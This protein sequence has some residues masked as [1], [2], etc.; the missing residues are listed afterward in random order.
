MVLKLGAQFGKDFEEYKNIE[1]DSS[2][3]EEGLI[4]Y[5]LN[6]EIPV[7]KGDINKKFRSYL[8]NSILENENNKCV[9]LI[10]VSPR[11]TNEQPLA[12]DMLTKSI[13]SNFIFTTPLSDN[14]LSDKYKRDSESKNVVA[15]MNIMFEQSLCSWNKDATPNDLSQLKLRRVYASKSIMAWTELFKD[16]ICAKLDVLDSDE[17]AKVFYRDISKNDFE[18]IKTI[19]IR[20]INWQMWSSPKNSEIDTVISS[21]RRTIKEWYKQKGLTV[22]YLVGA[23][24]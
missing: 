16:A 22:G 18:K 19:F 9:P 6:K 14:I 15:L 8:F 20:F 2:K 23:P 3:S 13:F 4:E 5:L 12:L 17:K 24:E 1:N 10:S 7:T 21:N 11:S